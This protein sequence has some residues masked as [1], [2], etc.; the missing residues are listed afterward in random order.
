MLPD[1]DPADGC[2][3]QLEVHDAGPGGAPVW[4][5]S[6]VGGGHAMPSIRHELADSA[7]VRRF[8]GPVCRDAEG[9]EIAWQFFRAKSLPS[10]R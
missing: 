9:A 5:Y 3:I 2:R 7:L 4:F 8:I 6:A 10:A 1:T